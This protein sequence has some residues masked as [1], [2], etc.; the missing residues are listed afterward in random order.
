[1]RFLEGVVVEDIADTAQSYSIWFESTDRC[2]LPARIPFVQSNWVLLLATCAGEY[3]NF[4]GFAAE[5]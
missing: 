4:C 3:W 2:R 1:M 5:P